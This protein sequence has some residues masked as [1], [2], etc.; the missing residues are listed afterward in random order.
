M[1]LARCRPK[2]GGFALEHGGLAELVDAHDLGSCVRVRVR[3][4]YPLPAKTQDEG[5]YIV[6]TAR[7][8]G[9]FGSVAQR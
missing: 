3:V 6:M 7:K 9:H 5:F 1:V 4:P 8:D 2:I